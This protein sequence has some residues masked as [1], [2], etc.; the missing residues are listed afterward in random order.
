MKKITA[1]AATAADA[2]QFA[3]WSL[4]A[5]ALNRFDPDV[6]EYPTTV[7]IA[8]ETDE[9]PIT[10]VP[11]HDVLMCESLAVNPK[12]TKLQIAQAIQK[13]DK[14]IEQLA[15]NIQVREL[16]FLSKSPALTKLAQANGYE[17]LDFSI[18]RRK[19]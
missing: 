3:E 17:K 11:I 2:E 15:R 6:L 19:I 4:A 5:R 7:V 8:T 18:L 16:Y 12:A 13:T 14:L 1:R 9:E 10:F